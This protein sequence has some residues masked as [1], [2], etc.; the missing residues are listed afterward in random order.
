MKTS[1]SHLNYKG[2]PELS[3]SWFPLPVKEKVRLHLQEE[4]PDEPFF[5]ERLIFVMFTRRRAAYTYGVQL[6]SEGEL[7]FL[8]GGEHSV[9]AGTVGR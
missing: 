4:V 8:V 6:L 1:A 5:N 2:F 9:V 3:V 7:R